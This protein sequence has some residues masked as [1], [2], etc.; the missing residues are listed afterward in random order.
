[1]HYKARQ[2]RTGELESRLPARLLP[3]LS[4]S[5]VAALLGGGKISEEG[6]RVIKG[7]AQNG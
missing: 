7:D 3:F 5:H 6:V 4:T 2:E 1:M